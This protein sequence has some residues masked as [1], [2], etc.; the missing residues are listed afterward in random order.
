MFSKHGENCSSLGPSRGTRQRDFQQNRCT[1]ATLT[2]T[3]LC[4]QTHPELDK[5]KHPICVLDKRKKRKEKNIC[6]RQTSESLHCRVNLG[7]S[8]IWWDAGVRRGQAAA[9]SA[10]P[11]ESSVGDSTCVSAKPVHQG[12]TD[13]NRS[14]CELR[15]FKFQTRNQ[16]QLQHKLHLQDYGTSGCALCWFQWEFGK[17]RASCLLQCPPTCRLNGLVKGFPVS[18]ELPIDS[19]LKSNDKEQKKELL[20]TK[21]NTCR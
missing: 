20:N 8:P 15:M 11:E 12:T 19:D 18:T 9:A 2:H 16:L 7:A 21:P 4:T 10:T 5:K 3:L 6:G 1:K 17:K 14:F 13:A